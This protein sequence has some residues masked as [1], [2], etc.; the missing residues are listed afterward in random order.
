MGVK[1][2]S[3]LFDPESVELLDQLEGRTQ[4]LEHSVILGTILDRKSVV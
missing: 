1:L 2:P 3:N 4:I